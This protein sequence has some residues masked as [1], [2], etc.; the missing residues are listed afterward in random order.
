MYLR[1]SL[2]VVLSL[3]GLLA[4]VSAQE[5]EEPSHRGRTLTEWRKDLK[6]KDAEVRRKAA[7]ALAQMGKDAAPA[8]PDLAAVL[9]DEK[10]TV[11]VA[12][13][14][15][16]WR[17]GPIA[18]DAAPAVIKVYQDV[19]QEDEV[20]MMAGFALGKI[21]AAHKDVVPTLIE[22]LRGSEK[23]QAVLILGQIGP[24]ARA[25]VPELIKVYEN[26]AMDP[27]TSKRAAEALKKIDP[28]AAAKAGIK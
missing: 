8:V 17:L 21:G 20:R 15:A 5:K 23:R 3:S 25:A 26:S 7:L 11:R 13:A 27:T 19:N 14:T 12:A 18:R 6:D 4:L 24:D 10:P 16:L 1:L 2:A 22:S 28:E 9:Q